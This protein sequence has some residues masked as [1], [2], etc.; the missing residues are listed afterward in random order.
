MWTV[1]DVKS[2]AGSDLVGQGA[3]LALVPG[4]SLAL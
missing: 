3:L 4:L 2:D 1:A